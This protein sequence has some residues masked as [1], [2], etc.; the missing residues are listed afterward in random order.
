M[1]KEDM[2]SIGRIRK[3][4]MKN[5]FVKIINKIWGKRDV[6]LHKKKSINKWYPTKNKNLMAKDI[7]TSSGKDVWWLSSSDDLW[8]G[9][10]F[11]YE[12]PTRI[13]QGANGTSCPYVSGKAVWYV[14][15]DNNKK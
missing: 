15:N 4:K 11:D 8:A 3:R 10:H 2:N 12:W 5:I 9:K 6:E 7:L 13:H 14:I 1:I